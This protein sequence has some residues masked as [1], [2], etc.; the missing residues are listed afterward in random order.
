MVFNNI[1]YLSVRTLFVSGLPVDIKPRELY[2]LFRP[3]KGYE[4]SLIKLTSKQPVGFVTFDNRTGAEAAKNAL[5]MRW[6][7]TPSETNQPGWKSRQ[8]C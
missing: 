6:Y 7:P 5:N 8:F 3:F 1:I 4:G 2:L